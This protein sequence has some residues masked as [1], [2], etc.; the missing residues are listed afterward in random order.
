MVIDCD[1]ERNLSLALLK[2][3]V[4]AAVDTI[5]KKEQQNK[6]EFLIS[7]PLTTVINREIKQK[8]HRTLY[9]QVMDND[10]SIQPVDAFNINENTWL[11]P[12]HRDI[13]NL[14]NLIFQNEMFNSP[15][16]SQFLLDKPND[17][18]GKP[19]ASIIKNA[20][21][22]KI[23]YVFLFLG[24]AAILN[25][26]L[27][28]SSHFLILLADNNLQGLDH[29][30]LVVNNLSKWSDKMKTAYNNMQTLSHP[31]NFPIRTTMPTFLSL[32]LNV[33]YRISE[34]YKRNKFLVEVT[35]QTETIMSTNSEAFIYK[36]IIKG[37][38][39]LTKKLR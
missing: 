3:Q 35:N 20:E 5:I 37:V 18:T 39:Y 15:Q 2:P 34:N 26:C 14:E 36:H 30:N 29:I 33:S 6:T 31:I 4:D 8:H 7:S 13:Y 16:L 11:V 9:D 24:K 27:I 10:L 38:N 21:T 19:Y 1:S 23:Y 28:F 17:K 25:R 12:G 22:Y 32:I